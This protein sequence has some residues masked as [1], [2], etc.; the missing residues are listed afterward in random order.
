MLSANNASHSWLSKSFLEKPYGELHLKNHFGPRTGSVW[1]QSVHKSLKEIYYF[2]SEVAYI[3]TSFSIKLIP[4]KNFISYFSGLMVPKNWV[5]FHCLY[6]LSN[7]RRRGNTDIKWTVVVAV[8]VVV[9]F[10]NWLEIA[11][12]QFLRDPDV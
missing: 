10:E 6:I 8:V 5:R 9:Y 2:W 7:P 4:K 11:L 12:Q 1:S 3:A